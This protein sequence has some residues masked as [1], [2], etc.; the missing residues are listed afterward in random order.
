MNKDRGIY[1]VITDIHGN[2]EALDAV[3][4]DFKAKMSNVRKKNGPILSKVICLGDIVGYGPD[5]E[6][7][8]EEAREFDIC[9]SGNH[10]EITR[11]L[12]DHPDVSR[13]TLKISEEALASNRWFVKQLIG[14]T[15][16]LPE[17][18]FANMQREDYEAWLA[19][20]I[21]VQK[22]AQ[23]KA[24]APELGLFRRQLTEEMLREIGI[25][26]L[27]QFLAKPELQKEYLLRLERRRT[28]V[29]I[30]DFI[31]SLRRKKTYSLENAMFVHD[32]PLNPGDGKYLVGDKKGQELKIDDR[33]NLRKINKTAFPGV[34]YLFVGHSHARPVIEEING[35]RVVY[36]GGAIPRLDNPDKLAG[37]IAVG[38]EDGKVQQVAPVEIKYDWKKTQ[39]KLREKGL[40]DFFGAK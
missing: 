8:L 40:H 7:C 21:A 24:N 38:V 17:E 26:Y 4:S 25:D 6:E 15:D 30:V 11:L 36:C 22:T 34:D 1:A 2:K 13:Q 5:P 29:R 20:Q 14:A 31:D 37:Y 9:L 16:N 35:I 12:F 27:K 32:N 3:L 28:A 10:E 18:R 23:F 33:V 39:A 19:E